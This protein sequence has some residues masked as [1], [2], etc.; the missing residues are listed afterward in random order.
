MNTLIS[1]TG[2]NLGLFIGMSIVS[3]LEILDLLVDVV[4]ILLLPGLYARSIGLSRETSNKV[5]IN[6][7]NRCMTY[8]CICPYNAVR[9][10][11]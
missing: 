1:N 3:F 2:G 10:D 4:I 8:A 6:S 9:A 5:G 7:S 11:E